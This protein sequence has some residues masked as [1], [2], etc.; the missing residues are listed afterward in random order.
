[1]RGVSQPARRRHDGCV[2][3]PGA[4]EG[5]SA[6]VP[7]A[8]KARPPRRRRSARSAAPDGAVGPVTGVS[9]AAILALALFAWGESLLVFDWA[10]QRF[11]EPAGRSALILTVPLFAGSIIAAIA[12]IRS[13]SRMIAAHSGS[14]ADLVRGRLL[15]GLGLASGLLALTALV[16][17]LWLG[18][19]LKAAEEDMR[20]LRAVRQI[21]DLA[22]ALA[23]YREAHGRHPDA[24]GGHALLVALA[25]LFVATATSPRDP[26]GHDLEYRSL[27]EGRGYLLLSPGRDGVQ[28]LPV[29]EYVESPERA[30]QGNDIVVVNGFFVGAGAIGVDDSPR[31]WQEPDL[32]PSGADPPGKRR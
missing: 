28:D 32:L 9:V 10:R 21:E 27:S 5:A 29:A 20:E 1:M 7:E 31:A 15:H 18:P 24:S 23:A 12:A 22:A 25:P 2:S 6:A 4:T 16:L 17:A 3:D 19:R 26:W 30:A 13:R 8:P 14:G 11:F